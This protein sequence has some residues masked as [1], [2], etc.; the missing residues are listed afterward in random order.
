MLPLAD[1]LDQSRVENVGELAHR[2]R[3][4]EAFRDTV[5]HVT[6]DFPEVWAGLLLFGGTQAGDEGTVTA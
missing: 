2:R 6:Q 3:Q 1:P 5:Q 4:R